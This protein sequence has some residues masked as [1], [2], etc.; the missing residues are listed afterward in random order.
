MRTI[1]MNCSLL[2]VWLSEA[3]LQAKHKCV[4]F[5]SES[6]PERQPTP[7]YWNQGKLLPQRPPK[8]WPGGTISASGAQGSQ[9]ETRFHQISATYVGLVYIKSDVDCQKSSR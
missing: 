2:S 9:F 5:S 3:F 1:A 7:M 8:Q 4:P 6:S